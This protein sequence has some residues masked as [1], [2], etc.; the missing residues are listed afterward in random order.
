VRLVGM[1]ADDVQGMFK[2]RID[3]RG[4]VYMLPQDVIDETIKA[5]S[6]SATA[7]SGYSSLGA[8]S[9]RYFAPANGPDCIE[10]APGFGDCGTG[11]LVVA[12]PVFRQ[13]D[14]AVSKR[15]AL[16]G[17]SNLE[18]RVEALNAFNHH[19]FDPANYVSTN[20][21]GG[22]GG[23][24]LTNYELDGLLGT[25]TSRLIQFIGRFNF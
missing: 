15:V 19:N 13:F 2:T 3:S 20:P 16:F 14:I 8:P 9:G 5:F 21:V 7:G 12:G 11:N 18:F 6:V 24:N 25:N 22:I 23:T 1:T 17:R 10:V 4:D